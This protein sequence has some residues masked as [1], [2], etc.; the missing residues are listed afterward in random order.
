M[1][2]FFKS[3][4]VSWCLSVLQLFEFYY[5]EKEIAIECSSF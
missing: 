3:V 5:V 1:D 2:Q 4:N